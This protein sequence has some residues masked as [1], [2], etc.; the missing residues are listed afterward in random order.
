MCQVHKFYLT[1]LSPDGKILD[2][3]C[4]SGRD[5]FFNKE[6]QVVAFNASAEMVKRR[7]QM[8]G[9]AEML[10]IFEE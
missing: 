3:G 2:A 9:Q 10:A 7:A 5:S 1:H 6:Y 4:G 8:I